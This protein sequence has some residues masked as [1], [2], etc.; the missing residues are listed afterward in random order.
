[1]NQ[2]SNFLDQ[3]TF[4][5]L[6]RQRRASETNVKR[7][8]LPPYAIRADYPELLERLRVSEGEDEQL[9]VDWSNAHFSDPAGHTRQVAG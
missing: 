7:G 3:Q 1:M 5:S 8:T 9:V 2:I 6:N 4:T